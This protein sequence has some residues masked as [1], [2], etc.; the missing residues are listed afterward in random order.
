MSMFV[1]CNCFYMNLHDGNKLFKCNPVIRPVLY[2][3]FL[4]L[5]L[6]GIL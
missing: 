1:I 2:H 6:G 5:T 3:E 4:H